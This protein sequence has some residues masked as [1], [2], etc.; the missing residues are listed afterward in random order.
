MGGKTLKYLAALAGCSVLCAA[1]ALLLT[2]APA[3]SGEPAAD[4]AEVSMLTD[5]H[6]SDIAGIAL[7]NGNGSIAL[8][9]Y[10]NEWSVLEAPEDTGVNMSA[11]KSFSYRMAHMPALEDLGETQDWEA[12]GL[13]DPQATVSIVQTD[14]SVTKIHMGD[15]TPL[16]KGYYARRENDFHLYWIDDVT[17]RMLCYGMDDL[18]AL[19]VLPQIG[20]SGLKGLTLFRLTHG[21]TTIEV[22][23]EE[24][25][26]AAR[27]YMTRP[28]ETALDWELVSEEIYTPLTCLDECRFVSADAPRAA[29]GLADE[30]RYCVELQYGGK[31]WVLTFADAGDGTFYVCREG[32]DQ[33]VSVSSSLLDFLSLQSSALVSGTLYSVSAA[34][35]S[36]VRVSAKDV[37]IYAE[38]SGSGENLSAVLNGKPIKRTQAL[39]LVKT[40][41]MLPQSGV[42]TEAADIAAE[43]LLRMSF[44]LRDGT[45]T[46]IEIVPVTERHCAFILNGSSGATVY[47]STAEELIREVSGC[48]AA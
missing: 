16:E 29:Y 42:L 34:E 9:L 28:F 30:D 48:L 32:S 21:E 12:Y 47:T 6:M 37:D 4:A 2:A 3:E 43:P 24:S 5:I 17:A 31:A 8:M 23:G 11:V 25:S 18:R 36:S 44:V 35:L 38:F 46:L 13:D 22:I 27:F 41:T 14:G 39:E 7:K 33:I 20:E 26:G 40:V 15:Q 45:E 10:Q 1:L 19:D